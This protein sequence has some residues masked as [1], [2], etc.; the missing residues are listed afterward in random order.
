MKAPP[1]VISLQPDWVLED[2][3]SSLED[4]TLVG[5]DFLLLNDE[6]SKVIRLL[7][8]SSGKVLFEIP[9]NN[10]PTELFLDR[11]ELLIQQNDQDLSMWDLAH[12]LQRW[13]LSGQGMTPISLNGDTVFALNRQQ[14]PVMLERANGQQRRC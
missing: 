1:A 12:G 7:H 10:S 13:E 11:N 9:T 14:R 5:S 6:S 3:G 8:L 4:P 2:M